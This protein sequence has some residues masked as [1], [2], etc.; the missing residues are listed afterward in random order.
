MKIGRTPAFLLVSFLCVLTVS[1]QKLPAPSPTVVPEKPE[2]D[3][4][5]RISTDLVLID[6]LV[7][8]KNNQQVTN[9]S[10]DDFEVYQDGKIQQITS[11]S[12]VDGKTRAVKA[13]PPRAGKKS[14]PVPPVSVRDNE[15][16]RIITFVIDDGNCLATLSGMTTA[17]EGVRKFIDKQM[18]P[19][20]KVAIY[21]TRGGSSLLQMYTSNKEVLRR[22][23]NKIR[24]VPSRCG[25]AYLAAIDKSPVKFTSQSAAVFESEADRERMKEIN[26]VENENQV[27]GTLGM[28]GFVVDRLKALPERKL[29]FLVSEGIT[30]RLGTKAYD[31]LRSV[32]DKATR[33]QVVI[34]TIGTKGV[35]VPG[36]ISAEDEVLPGIY[37]GQDDTIPLVESRN[38]EERALNEG[39]SYLAYSTGGKSIRN[40]NFI[41]NVVEKV[42][43]V[44]TGYYLLGYEPDGETFRG[45][46]YHRIE[47][48][49]KRPDL[50]LTSRKGFMGKP[51]S[52]TKTNNGKTASSIYEAIASPFVE[53]SLDLRLTPLVKSGTGI[54]GTVRTLFHLDGRNL[55]FSDDPGGMKKCVLNVVLV[56]LDEKGKVAQ[57]FNRVYPIRVPARAV[58]TLRVN[59]LDYSTDIV[60]R[61][62]GFYSLRLA[63]QDEASKRIG[64]AG[65]YVEIPNVAKAGFFINAFVTTAAADG[66]K[67]LEPGSRPLNEG[68]APV[69][70]TEAASTRQYRA[71]EPIPYIYD[72]YNAKADETTGRPSLSFRLLLYKDGVLRGSF[73]DKKVDLL[74]GSGGVK[75]EDYGFLRLRKDIEPGEYILQLV[76]TDNVAGKVSSQWIDFE[77]VD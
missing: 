24:W 30:A 14:L 64:S 60:L 55:T 47:I 34:Y 59:G 37:T 76:V 40:Q 7:V 42:L 41:E 58:E 31:A 73:P 50:F 49:L 46:Q 71:G 1:A 48:K 4:V 21:R 57:E 61:K 43:E 18:R 16:G 2:S 20:D 66:N 12:Y 52:S 68:F 36:F 9:L 77:V 51:D 63:V 54:G 6:A 44:E 67:P 5:I 35:S 28:L 32:T 56:A 39:M 22:T 26:R 13:A 8:D 70:Q 23:V 3:D 45:T 29:L 10:P 19:D 75:I 74:P 65:D 11:F 25:S 69:F 62:P 38:E 33:S 72:I 17:R 27:V 15:L 53:S